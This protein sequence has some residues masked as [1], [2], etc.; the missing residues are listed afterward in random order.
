MLGGSL[1]MEEQLCSGEKDR[2]EA[3]SGTHHT[4]IPLAL[5]QHAARH[6]PH[7]LGTKAQQGRRLDRTV[8]VT[9]TGQAGARGS[10]RRL[11]CH[12]GGSGRPRSPRT[13]TPRDCSP[14]RGDRGGN[15]G[16]GGTRGGHRGS[17]KNGVVLM[18]DCQ[19][20]IRVSTSV[21]ALGPILCGV[22]GAQSISA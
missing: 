5:I 12:P 22:D 10:P 11:S 13:A 17:P 19:R 2:D 18:C 8:R 16:N 14:R 7:G 21:A 6:C 20:R 3:G 9:T 4:E 15:G 1:A